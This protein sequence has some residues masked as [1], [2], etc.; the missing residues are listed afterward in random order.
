VK[1]ELLP[2]GRNGL[3]YSCDKVSISTLHSVVTDVLVGSRDSPQNNLE[4]TRLS[5]K[6]WTVYSAAFLP[7][8]L[9]TQ[10]IVYYVTY[11]H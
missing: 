6:F 7:P 8:I 10:V 9:N 2:T 3:P 1:T 5:L 11:D 4:A